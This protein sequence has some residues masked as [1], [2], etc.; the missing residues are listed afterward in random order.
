MS[1]TITPAEVAERLG[2]GEDRVRKVV[3]QESMA[4]IPDALRMVPGGRI[5]MESGSKVLVIF[6]GIFEA[7][8]S[9]R[10]VTRTVLP[11][12]RSIDASRAM[13]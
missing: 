13:S 9:G 11:L 1:D 6:S 12:I 10:A 7:V 3:R 5:D 2:I 8:T 4:L